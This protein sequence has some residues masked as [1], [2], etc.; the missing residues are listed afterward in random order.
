MRAQEQCPDVIAA[1][2]L[3]GHPRT[4]RAAPKETS[5]ASLDVHE[6]RVV[7]GSDTGD[8]RV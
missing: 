8:H 7:L 5:V 2:S 3:L 1:P 4:R 6:R